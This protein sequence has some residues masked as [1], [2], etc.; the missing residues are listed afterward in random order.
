MRFAAITLLSLA[1][2]LP[3]RAESQRGWN[4]MGRFSGTANSSSS[5]LKFDPSA[6]YVFSSHLEAYGGLP[7]YFV[8]DSQASRSMSGIGNLYA[9]L[10]GRIDSDVLNYVSTI[11]LSAPTGDRDR[12]FSTGR[13]TAD[14]TNRFSR[15]F[16]AV[17]PFASAGIAN[18]ISDTSFFV[19]PFTSLGLVTHFE[20]GA[21]ADLSDTF[22]AGASGY[23]IRASGEQRII[24]RIVERENG[25]ANR[26]RGRGQSGGRN[27][28][29]EVQPETLV[30]AELVD[31]HGFSA[32]FGISPRRA[33][34][35]YAGYNRSVT[36]NFNSVFFGL[37]VRVGK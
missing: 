12:G 26:A 27:R 32:W 28:V 33:L 4:F 14:W 16:S 13:M 29:F 35:F 5:V 30:A 37:E 8:R 11:E 20:A 24:S 18:T 10:Q 36:Y 6:G 15:S 9:G 23:A 34:N 2:A 17:T 22:R 31:D 1:L 21:Q 25:S 3:V 19:R 7:V